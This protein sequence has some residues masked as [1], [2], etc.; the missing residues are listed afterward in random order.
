M[1]EAS[2]PVTT[3][4]KGDELKL[5]AVVERLRTLYKDHPDMLA[6]VYSEQME[7]ARHYNE[8]IWTIGTILV[9]VSFAALAINFDKQPEIERFAAFASCGILTFWGLLTEWHRRLWSRCF[10]LT[11]LIEELWGIRE[12]AVTDADRVKHLLHFRT[13]FDLGYYLLGASLLAE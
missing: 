4:A 7:W 3:R 2:I 13:R 12:K 8:L 1:S 10:E 5:T 9:P 6:S 11:G